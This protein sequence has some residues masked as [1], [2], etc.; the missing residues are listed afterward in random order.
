M[1][2]VTSLSPD[3]RRTEAQREAVDS[4]RAA[5]LSVQS[6]N[7]L[8]EIVA[9]GGTYGV[10]Y[11]PCEH[12]TMERFGRHCVPATT[13]LA[14]L[15][16]APG[17]GVLL[18]SD[19]VL[20]LTAEQLKRFAARCGDGLG[21]LVKYTHDGDESRGVREPYGL[22]TFVLDASTV[23]LDA[24]YLSLGQPVWDYWLPY[25]Y[26]RTGRTLYTT[27]DRATFHRRHVQSWDMQRWE[28]C[29][30]EFCRV[31]HLDAIKTPAECL[32]FFREL[33]S[34]ID[35]AQRLSVLE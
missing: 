23:K 26:L 15:A 35:Q 14:Q 4:W 3:P 28:E 9:M 19:I 29:A 1:L 5:G 10:E 24:S 32:T 30:A 31:Y 27:D 22:D 2:A 11:V 6:V 18:N 21:Y 25:E 20:R 7:H 13:L 34:R 8:S 33:H 12:T 17:P 16:T